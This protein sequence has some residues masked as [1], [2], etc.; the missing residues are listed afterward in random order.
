MPTAYI[1]GIALR[2]KCVCIR[3]FGLLALRVGIAQLLRRLWAAL[4]AL[5]AWLTRRLDYA[6]QYRGDSG[7]GAGSVQAAPSH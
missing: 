1:H 4:L 7:S 6:H 2:L 5:G 3:R